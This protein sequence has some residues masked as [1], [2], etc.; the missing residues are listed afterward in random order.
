[1][2]HII[3][4]AAAFIFGMLLLGHILEM[5]GDFFSMIRHPIRTYREDPGWAIA[6]VWVLIVIGVALY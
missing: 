4:I 5:I 2:L 3:G 6:L 1:M